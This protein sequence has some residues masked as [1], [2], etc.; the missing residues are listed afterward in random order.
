MPNP[1]CPRYSIDFTTLTRVSLHTPRPQLSPFVYGPPRRIA[2]AVV[3]FPRTPRLSAL[4]VRFALL[5][6]FFSLLVSEVYI[7]KGRVQVSNVW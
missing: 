1:G 4:S 2:D 6:S 3:S 5:C 7:E